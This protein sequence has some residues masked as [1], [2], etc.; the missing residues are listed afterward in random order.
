[1]KIHLITN[2]KTMALGLRFA[3]ISSEIVTDEESLKKALDIAISDKEIGIIL[4]NASAIELSRAYIMKLKIVSRR[5][6][7]LKIPDIAN[8]DSFE[9]TISSRIKKIFGGGFGV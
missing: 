9:N 3:G 1:M 4:I 2:D 6:I 8:F 7:I 5:R